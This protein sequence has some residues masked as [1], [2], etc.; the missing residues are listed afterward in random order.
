[1]LNPKNLFSI[2]AVAVV[3]LLAATGGMTPS[4]AQG[5]KPAEDVNVVN[6]PTVN[7]QQAGTWTVGAQLAPGTTVGISGTP[8]VSISGTPTVNVASLPALSVGAEPAFPAVAYAASRNLTSAASEV[9]F[10]QTVGTIGLTA[11]T[12][13]NFDS[14]PVQVTV[15]HA[16]LASPGTCV[17]AAVGGT[18]P[19]FTVWVQERS[20][21]HLTYPTALVFSRINDASCIELTASGLVSGS[22]QIAVSGFRQL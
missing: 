19:Q 18:Q 14:T 12:L 2:A 22:V 9:V 13:S 8:A 7:A 16:I 5:L 15:S 10:G 1:M 3:A 11:I 17:G 21:L 4:N 20:T 6:T